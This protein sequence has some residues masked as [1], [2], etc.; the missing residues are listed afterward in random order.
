MTTKLASPFPRSRPHRHYPIDF[1]FAEAVFLSSARPL[2]IAFDRVL[3]RRRSTR[4]FGGP[5][6]CACLGPLLWLAAKTRT[7]YRMAGLQDWQSRPYPSAG[8]CYEIHLLALN[9]A[10][11]ADAAF[12]Y[13]PRHHALGVLPQV[14]ERQIQCILS[15]MDPILPAR[16][17][18]VL[19][20]CRSPQTGRKI[21]AFGKPAMAK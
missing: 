6:S 11:H 14:T 5:L 15:E 7:T 17:A 9:V 8:G 1:G 4:E 20:P 3:S 19:V 16:R 2:R 10:E 12:I 18:T 21:R 13:D